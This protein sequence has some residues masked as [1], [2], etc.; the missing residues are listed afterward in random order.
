[1][2]EFYYYKNMYW[3]CVLDELGHDVAQ[4]L[5]LQLRNAYPNHNIIIIAGLETGYTYAICSQWPD[6]EVRAYA[7]SLLE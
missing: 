4:E 5:F 6:K 7:Q 2:T 3:Y 1:M